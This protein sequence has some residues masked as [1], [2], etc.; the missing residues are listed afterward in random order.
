MGERRRHLGRGE[1]RELR[2]RRARPGIADLKGPET[3]QVSSD[4]R[5]VALELFVGPRAGELRLLAQAD[6]DIGA[7][8]GRRRLVAPRRQAGPFAAT[9]QNVLQPRI[10]GRDVALDPSEAVAR[11]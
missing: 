9:W 3:L 5:V 4:G 8:T 2:L 7:R 10:N 11:R 1:R 6:R